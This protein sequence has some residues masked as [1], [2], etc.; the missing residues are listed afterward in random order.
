MKKRL[1]L[2][3]LL[4][5]FLLAACSSYDISAKQETNLPPEN[6]NLDVP[7][8][9]NVVETYEV[10]EEYTVVQVKKESYA[11]KFQLWNKITNQ[12][13][14]FPT[15]PAFVE[16]EDV[17]SPEYFVFLS[18]GQDSESS[19][20]EF[21]KIIKC[22]KTEYAEEPFIRIDEDKWFDLSE[23][24]SAGSTVSCKL[25]SVN[26]SFDSVSFL[27]APLSGN[28]SEFYADAPD[29]PLTSITYE[30]NSH[31]L[32]VSLSS[33][34]FDAMQ[35]KI[36]DTCLEMNPYVND[37]LIQENTDETVVTLLLSDEASGYYAMKNTFFEPFFTLSFSK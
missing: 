36:S 28:E 30:E 6:Q 32:I 3:C 22:F 11:P 35:S 33:C 27:F 14:T 15:M 26:F 37:Y 4:L 7:N 29:I 12:V 23:N 8:F 1:T 31:S 21:P 25:S 9:E 13:D 34:T 19:R 17:K 24:V 5:V 16:L 2:S 18:T 10:N 20:L